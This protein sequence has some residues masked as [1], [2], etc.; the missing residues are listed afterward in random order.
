LQAARW[1]RPPSSRNH[2]RIMFVV[3]GHALRLVVVETWIGPSDWARAEH[4]GGL[5]A[6]L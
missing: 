3:L 5:H 4:R 6:R 2:F 1:I